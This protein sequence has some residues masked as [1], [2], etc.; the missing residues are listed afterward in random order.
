[1]TIDKTRV[2]H[3]YARYLEHPSGVTD[4]LDHW[5]AA[6]TL[7][8]D[9][10][11][12]LA[13]RP[14]G[15]DRNEF[16]QS[17]LTKTIRHWGRGRG[18]WIPIGLARELRKDDILYL[19]EGWVFSNVAAAVIARLK[20]A[21]TVVMPHGVYEKQIVQNQRDFL[22]LRRRLEKYI[23]KHASAVHVFY[24]GE[25]DVVREFEP[26]V[27]TF[28]TLPNG[29]PLVPEKARWTGSGDYFLWI[30][31]FDVFHKG[32]DNLVRFW[33]ELPEPKPRLVLAGPNF[34]GG[35]EVIADLVDRL[36]LSDVVELRGRITGTEKDQLLAEARAY[37]H[38]SRWESCSIMLLEATAAG[39]PS[40]ISSS[41]HAA[42]ELEPIGVVHSTS[43]EI[44]DSNGTDALS[45]VDRNRTLGD[46][47]LAWARTEG[48]WATVSAELESAQVKIG[49]RKHGGNSE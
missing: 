35:R 37:I 2:R 34:A 39:V 13:A 9:D 10:V 17:D 32:L 7:A 14:R 44:A 45:R 8:G 23:L 25:Q 29:A 12:I 30:G 43:F 41:I 1:M 42:D 27:K 15:A 33:S 20:G 40:L 31:R 16:A 49:V 19:H 11:E 6:S 26:S 46:A 24:A 47:A 22:G 28:I 38:P 36:G 48:S 18:T 3:Y 21:K 4:A 5:A